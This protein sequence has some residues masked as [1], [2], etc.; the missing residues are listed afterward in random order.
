MMKN[1]PAKK[2]YDEANAISAVRDSPNGGL[3]AIRASNG[4][5][6]TLPPVLGP[7]FMPRT[8]PRAK[9]GTE[10]IKTYEETFGAFQ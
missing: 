4:W 3:R 6:D 5:D 7:D 8:R 10:I 2:N 1:P 9:H